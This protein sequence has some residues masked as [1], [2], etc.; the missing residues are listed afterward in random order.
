MVEKLQVYK[1]FAEAM[2]R[3]QQMPQIKKKKEEEEEKERKK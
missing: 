2:N 1:S 3:K